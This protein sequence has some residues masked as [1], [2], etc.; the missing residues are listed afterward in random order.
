MTTA[1]EQNHLYFLESG[2]VRSTFSKLELAMVDWAQPY[3][4]TLQREYQL[5]NLCQ[6]AEQEILK[7]LD[8]NPRWSPVCVYMTAQPGVQDGR[9]EIG[10]YTIKL[11][12]VKQ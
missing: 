1:N 10:E 12:R 5:T 6:R 4:H 7:L 11:L 8:Q 3:L 9:I 2:V